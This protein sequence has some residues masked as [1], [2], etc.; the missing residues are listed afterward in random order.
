MPTDT[1]R[2]TG[3]ESSQSPYDY[4]PAPS[5]DLK[6]LKGKRH[7]ERSNSQLRPLFLRAGVVSHARGSGYIEMDQ[8]KVICAVYGPREVLRREDFSLKGQLTCDFKFTTFSCRKRRQ[9][10]QDNQEKDLSLQ[11]LEALEPALCLHKYPKSQINIYIT[12]LQ[13]DGCALSASVICASLA[14]ASAGIEMYDLVLAS[15]LGVYGS[16]TLVDPTSLEEETIL[17]KAEK[18]ENN[19]GIVTVAFLPSISQVSAITSDGELQ[20]DAVSKCM[21][22]CVENC[23]KLYPVLQKALF[24]HVK[25][26]KESTHS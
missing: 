22:A 20:F 4:C 2:I 18:S 11:I 8:T 12:V 17:T 10:Q 3:P 21:H 16:L 7:D 9:H 26:K 23:Q 13:N 1:K 24:D 14:L 5:L 25:E 6:N 19:A 15:S